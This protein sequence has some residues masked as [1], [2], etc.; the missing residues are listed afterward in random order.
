M[1]GRRVM[2]WSVGRDG[3]REVGGWNNEEYLVIKEV[4]SGNTCVVGDD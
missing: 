3:G 2:E 4:I 1:F